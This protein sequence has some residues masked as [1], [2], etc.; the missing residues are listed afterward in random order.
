MRRQ[1]C[2]IRIIMLIFAKRKLLI[3]CMWNEKVGDSTVIPTVQM[4]IR[5]SLSVIITCKENMSLTVFWLNWNWIWKLESSIFTYKV[6]NTLC[7]ISYPKSIPPQKS[8]ILK[9]SRLRLRFWT[10][11]KHGWWVFYMPCAIYRNY[12]LH[13]KGYVDMFHDATYESKITIPAFIQSWQICLDMH[14]KCRLQ[15]K[16]MHWV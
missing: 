7:R 3:C 4:G 16:I 9:S 13:K 2:L 6:P 8:D 10:K 11:R 12:H 15:N 5:V 14:G 1:F